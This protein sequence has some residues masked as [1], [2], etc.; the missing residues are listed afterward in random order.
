MTTQNANHK[1]NIL[2]ELADSLDYE[3]KGKEKIGKIY[4]VVPGLCSHEFL[5]V[6]LNS[7]AQNGGRVHG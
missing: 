3:N 2:R 4:V 6:K 7:M 1:T 5:F